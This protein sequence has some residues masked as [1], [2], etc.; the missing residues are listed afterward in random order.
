MTSVFKVIGLAASAR[1]PGRTDRDRIV[2]ASGERQ[3]GKYVRLAVIADI[4]GNLPALEAVLGDIARRDVDRTINLGDSV[5]GPMWPSETMDLL[6]RGKLLTVRG[7]HDRWVAQTPRE[8]MYPSDAY[9]HDALTARQR[10]ALGALPAVW[11]LDL[12]ITADHGTEVDDNQY[13]LE[14]VVQGRLV[15]AAPATIAGRL[16]RERN[17][18]LLCGHSHLPRIVQAADG[19]LIVN[20][21]S[22]GCPAY[23]DPDPPSHFSESG[24][25]HARYALLSQSARGW[26]IDLIAIEYDWNAASVRA[27]ENGRA[28]WARALVSGFI[29]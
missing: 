1:T 11:R 9:A 25:P 2:R 12:G 7:N 28:D 26:S 13:L 20:P 29:S 21:G 17:G 22:V 8:R 4:H 18:L 5:S 19:I 24:S 23:F 6:E 14:D 15:L 10:S 3:R 27:T 16:N